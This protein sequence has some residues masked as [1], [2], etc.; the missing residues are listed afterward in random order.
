MTFNGSWGWQ[1]TPP[2]DWH[3]ARKVIEMLNTCSAGQG[4]LLLNIGPHPD[5]SVPREAVERLTAVGRWLKTYGAA[6]AYGHVDRASRIV[7]ALGKWSCKGR[8]HYFWCGRWP[9]CELAIGALDGELESAR[10]LPSGQSLPFEQVRG[11][12]VIRGLPARCPDGLTGVG[13]IELTFR[14]PPNQLFSAGCVMPDAAPAQAGRGR[15]SPP[16][17]TWMVSKLMPKR[18]TVASAAPRG[19]ADPIGWQALRVAPGDG[20]V[21]I[22]D[23][24]GLVDGLLYLGARFRVSRAGRWPMLVGHDGGV[25][26]F[27][28]G[29]TVLTESAL[30]NP[31]IA[32]RSSATVPLAKG[33]HEVVIALDTAAGLGWGIIFQWGAPDAG[34]KPVYPECIA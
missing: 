27:V 30:K 16:V 15:A 26:V 18:G 14:T 12:L 21:N 7:S 13:V 2:E 6:A 4:N 31:A 10:L 9:G 23:R 28:D 34:R 17:I 8:T 29:Q 5:G 33:I 11:R 3:S 19:L 24:V 20:F 32:G 25:R 22:H 1:Q